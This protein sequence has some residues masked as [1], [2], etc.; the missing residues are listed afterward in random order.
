SRCFAMTKPLPSGSRR[1]WMGFDAA[2]NGTKSRSPTVDLRLGPE[3]PNIVAHPG[4][5]RNPFRFWGNWEKCTAVRS[6]Q[7]SVTSG[8]VD[9]VERLLGVARVAYPMPGQS[10]KRRRLLL[11]PRLRVQD[12]GRAFI[13]GGHDAPVGRE[14]QAGRLDRQ[15]ARRV[16]FVERMKPLAD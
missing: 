3:T 6:G 11:R 10:R 7:T 15:V 2:I 12:E 5:A 13:A 4:P 8:T 16:F 9:Q 1:C 14:G